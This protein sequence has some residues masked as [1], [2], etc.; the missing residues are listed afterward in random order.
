MLGLVGEAATDDEIDE[1]IR[2][3]DSDGDGQ[4]TYD[5]FYKL[6]VGPQQERKVPPKPKLPIQTAPVRLIF[7]PSKSIIITVKPLRATVLVAYTNLFII[8]K[9]LIAKISSAYLCCSADESGRRAGPV[10]NCR[11]PS[12]SDNT[13]GR[14]R[15]YEAFPH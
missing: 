5:E 8:R 10:Q 12:R 15:P 11:G 7:N 2:M 6:M 14:R 9:C 1:M 3:C 4:V 13:V